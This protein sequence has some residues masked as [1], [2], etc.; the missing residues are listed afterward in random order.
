MNNNQSQQPNIPQEPQPTIQPEIPQIPQKPSLPTWLIILI[1]VLAISVISVGAY[2]AYQ[3]YFISEPEPAELP[4]AGEEEL[5]DPIADLSIENLAQEDWQILDSGIINTRYNIIGKYPNGWVKDCNKN[6]CEVAN[7]RGE[8][9]M[10]QNLNLCDFQVMFPSETRTWKNIKTN[11]YKDTNQM[12]DCQ[13]MLDEIE[14][15]LKYNDNLTTDWQT[16]R[17]EEYGFSFKYPN[18]WKL[19]EN[20]GS[21]FDLSIVSI[22]SPETEEAFRNQQILYSDD[23]SIYYHPLV[24]DEPENRDNKIGATTIEG[25]IDKNPTII[26]IGSIEIGET[27]ATDVIWGGMG[28]YYVILAINNSHLY[29][30]W[31]SNVDNKDKLTSIEKVILSTFKFIK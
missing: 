22:T 8:G 11:T 18:N 20:S 23:I 1:T 17:N 4:I 30:I 28:A 9:I 27:Q 26:K 31:F 6:E 3:Y 10:E 19:S 24:A 21:N 25:L 16:Y 15:S 29:K 5:A 14:S 7:Y 13:T 12:A 2:A